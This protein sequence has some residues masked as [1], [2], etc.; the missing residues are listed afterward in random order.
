MRH[1]RSGFEDKN[2]KGVFYEGP[3]KKYWRNGTSCRI[4][5]TTVRDMGTK[6]EGV[7]YEGPIEML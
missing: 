1:R 5:G 3:R 7:M 2:E 6:E 4:R